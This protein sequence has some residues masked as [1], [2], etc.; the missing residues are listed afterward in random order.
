MKWRK[1]NSELYYVIHRGWD[2]G[3][4]CGLEK[5]RLFPCAWAHFYAKVFS[6][7]GLSMQQ[8]TCIRPFI[9]QHAS[10]PCSPR[11]HCLSPT[12]GYGGASSS[13]LVWSKGTPLW[14]AREAG[15]CDG[16]WCIWEGRASVR[17]G[18]QD[19]VPPQHS[20]EGS[21]RLFLNQDGYFWA[22]VHGAADFTRS[23]WFYNYKHTLCRR[24]RMSRLRISTRKLSLAVLQ[25][26]IWKMLSVDD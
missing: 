8:G 19:A 15:C 13:S 11:P 5:I 9:Y 26:G 22:G 10:S 21:L 25:E 6:Q 16:L 12:A 7:Q 23:C 1:I 14:G 18:R 2:S 17:E 24:S 3:V 4:L 20:W